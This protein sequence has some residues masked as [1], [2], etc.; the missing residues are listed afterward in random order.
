MLDSPQHVIHSYLS[1][2]L[3][4]AFPPVLAH[5]AEFTCPEEGV[6]SVWRRSD[7]SNISSDWAVQGTRAPCPPAEG[8]PT[9]SITLP[10]LKCLSLLCWRAP[11]PG[12]AFPTLQLRAKR[13]R[14]PPSLKPESP[15][16]LLFQ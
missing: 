5:T 16:V 13:I 4:T 9:G 15:T 14:K 8:S 2:S 6:R 1:L 12:P 7:Q 11:F 10:P 3:F